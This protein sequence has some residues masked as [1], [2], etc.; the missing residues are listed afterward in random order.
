MFREIGSKS[1][2]AR[3]LN[4][5]ANV[6]REEGDFDRAKRMY[7]EVLAIGREIGQKSYVATSLSNIANVHEDQGDLAAA[8]TD[9]RGGAGDCARDRREEQRHADHRET[10]RASSES[11]VNWPG[12]GHS[13][14]N[15][16]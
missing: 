11:R 8:Q 9:E 3:A 2:E 1:G 7:A 15:R 14:R 16:S 13:S 10:S 6:F 4:G 5:I 12:P